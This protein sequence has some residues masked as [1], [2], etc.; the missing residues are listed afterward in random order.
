MNHRSLSFYQMLALPGAEKQWVLVVF[1]IIS[2]GVSGTSVSVTES[3]VIL[4]N[5]GKKRLF[6]HYK[7]VD[8][9]IALP[10]LF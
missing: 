1:L 6:V 9:L 8:Y 4:N 10:T 2:F 7:W 5:E 3:V